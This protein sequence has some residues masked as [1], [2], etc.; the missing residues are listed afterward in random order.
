MVWDGDTPIGEP[1]WPAVDF[2]ASNPPFLGTKK[3]GV[4]LGDKYVETLFAL[5]GD[6]IP[7]FSDLYYANS[8]HQ[9]CGD[10]CDDQLSS[11]GSDYH[12]FSTAHDP[13]D[14]GGE[15]GK[16]RDDRLHAG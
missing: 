2:I 11:F 6:R 10:C 13:G 12:I 14:R 5:Y 4:G 8:T 7:N 9:T 3:L 1:E 16:G 15:F